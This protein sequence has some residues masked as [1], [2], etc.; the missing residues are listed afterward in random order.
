MTFELT[1]V[2]ALNCTMVLDG[3]RPTP[4]LAPQNG[5]EKR[6]SLAPETTYD[7]IGTQEC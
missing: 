1:G 7:V 6:L 3:P 2:T 4:T 5:T